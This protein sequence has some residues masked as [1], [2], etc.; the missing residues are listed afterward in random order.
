[1]AGRVES[2]NP[3]FAKSKA[4]MMLF[5]DKLYLR[6]EDLKPAPFVTVDKETLQVVKMDP[7]LKFEP[8]EGETQSLNWVE[9]DEVSGRSLAYTPLITDGELIY[10]IARKGLSKEQ[11]EAGEEDGGIPELVVEVYDPSK[12]FA[13]VRAVALTKNKHLDKFKK[14]KNSED[15]LK[16][17][18]W[19]TNGSYLVCFTKASKVK[20]FSL[21]TGIRKS[22]TTFSSHN[23]DQAFTYSHLDNRFFYFHKEDGVL[24]YRAFDFPNFKRRAPTA[25][26][27]AVLEQQ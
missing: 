12:G 9:T 13:F 6:Y 11:K 10:V 24:R 2:I 23:S 3:D 25:S 8:K 4:S 15:W 19:A 7:E 21:E 26:S 20:F 14:E 18:H 5:E 27:E 17:T 22:K 1:M 16:S